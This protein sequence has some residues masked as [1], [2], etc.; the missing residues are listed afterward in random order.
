MSTDSK[1]FENLAAKHASSDGVRNLFELLATRAKALHSLHDELQQVIITNREMRDGKPFRFSKRQ[2][3]LVSEF[4]KDAQDSA[5]ELPAHIARLSDA[6]LLNI[7]LKS[8]RQQAESE[9]KLYSAFHPEDKPAAE[10]IL[11][12]R[13]ETIRVI[14]D[15]IEHSEFKDTV[16]TK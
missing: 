3:Q 13:Q 15:F 16:S 14:T 11:A 8:E 5:R 9:R 2:K 6:A 10:K 4:E 1:Q 12:F 7:A